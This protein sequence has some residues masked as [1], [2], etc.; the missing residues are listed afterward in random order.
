MT[1]FALAL[2]RKPI[3]GLV[4]PARERDGFMTEIARELFPSADSED[5]YVI[6]ANGKSIEELMLDAQESLIMKSEFDETELSEVVEKLLPAVD[7]LVF[8]YSSDYTD[9]DEAHDATHVLRALEDAVSE[10][11]CELYL[12]YQKKRQ[13]V[14]PNELVQP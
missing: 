11:T 8:W 9:L 5:V 1:Q 4:S 7:E 6:N 14:G 13:S 12:R 3:V 10:S 2:L